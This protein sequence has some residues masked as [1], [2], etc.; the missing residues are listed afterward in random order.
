MLG[1]LLIASDQGGQN[2]N[3]NG[4]TTTLINSVDESHR[5]RSPIQHN[6]QWI[7]PQDNLFLLLKI[8][9]VP[10]LGGSHN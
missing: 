7:I 3:K 5:A 4:R 8:K 2:S 10:R 6:S 1:A 9:L